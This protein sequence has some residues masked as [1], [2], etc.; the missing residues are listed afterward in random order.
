MLTPP[1]SRLASYNNLF[2]LYIS[3]SICISSSSLHVIIS[4]VSCR[5]PFICFVCLHVKLLQITSD[6]E[7][8]IGHLLNAFLLFC[9][10]A[11][12]Q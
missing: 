1:L 8:A 12:V 10:G 6:H 11:V 4:V 7:T 2:I 9:G 5:H 3:H